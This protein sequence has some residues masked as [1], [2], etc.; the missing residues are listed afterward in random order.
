MNQR[1]LFNRIMHYEDFDRMPHVYWTCWPETMERWLTEGLPERDGE[2]ALFGTERMSDGVPVDLG[3]FP[4][5]EEEVLEE[6]DEYRVF[7]Q[8]DGVVCKDWKNQSCIP[9]YIDFLL[10]DPSSWPEYKK[11]LQPDPARLPDDMDA[12]AEKLNQSPL[13]VA[14]HTTS[15]I[16][17]LR[18]WMGAEN[19]AV[20]SLLYPELLEDYVETMSD[21]VCWAI[22]QWAPKV[23]IDMGWGWEDI[24]FKSGPL[25]QPEAFERYCV[26]GYRKISDKLRAY[27]CDLHVIDCDGLIDHLVPG[28][29]EGGVNVLFPVEIGTWKADPM[30]FRKKYGKELRVYGGIDKLELEKGRAAIDAEIEKR[31]PLMADG[32][33]IPLPDHI[34]TPGTSLENMQYYLEQIQKLRF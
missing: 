30:A 4:K 33:F 20:A 27:G 28:W 23:R 19:V 32:G 10:K 9:H 8:D 17:T 25:I 7:R 12:Q 5:F 14:I 31:L 29:L 22:D 18:N 6:T 24:C 26:P 13:P 15:M 11:R 1:E 34:I 16:G 3:L 2:H 21:L